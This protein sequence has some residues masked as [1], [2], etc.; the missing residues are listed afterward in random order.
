MTKIPKTIPRIVRP[1]VEVKNPRWTRIC[2]KY[3]PPGWSL[4]CLATPSARKDGVTRR[5]VASSASPNTGLSIRTLEQRLRF[6]AR[7][8]MQIR[9]VHQHIHGDDVFEGNPNYIPVG[10]DLNIFP[11]SRNIEVLHDF[12]DV[13]ANLVLGVVVHHRI[14]RLFL[15]SVGELIIV[16]VR[17]HELPRRVNPQHQNDYNED[18]LQP[19]FAAF[20]P[21]L[22][23]LPAHAHAVAIHSDSL[24][25]RL[26]RGLS[27]S[28][29]GGLI[30]P[31]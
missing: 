25:G 14:T 28:E 22:P 4:Y 8:K 9:V 11:L 3:S 13:V 26:C 12:K 24:L 17:W 19:A 31:L 1:I 6:T 15:H 27:A 10:H 20:E 7:S 29:N 5:R 21:A 18:A 30:F 2:K 16:H 23:Q